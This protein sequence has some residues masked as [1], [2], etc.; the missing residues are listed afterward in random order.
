[1]ILKLNEELMTNKQVEHHLYLYNISK[2]I[3][4]TSYAYYNDRKTAMQDMCSFIDKLCDTFHKETLSSRLDT[5][6]CELLCIL[7]ED[8][9]RSIS[10]GDKDTIP[11]YFINLFLKDLNM[12]LEED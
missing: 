9:M 4:L 6:Q 3:F 5:F 7:G 11:L 10:L 2:N 1:M 12:V 8:K